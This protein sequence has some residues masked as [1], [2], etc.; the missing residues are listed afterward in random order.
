[1]ITHSSFEVGVSSGVGVGGG[2]WG[3]VGASVPVVLGQNYVH[4][5]S[6]LIYKW[7]PSPTEG[8]QTA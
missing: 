7:W 3:G 1:M 6:H 2:A 5:Q 8:T 4:I